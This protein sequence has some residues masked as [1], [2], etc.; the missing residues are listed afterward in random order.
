M[1]GRPLERKGIQ[2][3]LACGTSAVMC[4]AC[5]TRR[6]SPLA[7]MGYAE[8]VPNTFAP[9]MRL[10]V[11]RDILLVGSTECQLLPFRPAA[12]TNDQ[13]VCGMRR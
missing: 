7:Q 5:L 10:C 9:S 11:S 8:Q 13:A 6:K 4:P 2:H 12:V 1:C 3:D